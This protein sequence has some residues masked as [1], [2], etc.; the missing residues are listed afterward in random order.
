MTVDPK[1]IARESGEDTRE[2]QDRVIGHFRTGELTEDAIRIAIQTAA[3]IGAN[4]GLRKMLG[5][6]DA[7]TTATL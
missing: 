5:V 7:K 6:M 2:L 1:E 3:I 4:T